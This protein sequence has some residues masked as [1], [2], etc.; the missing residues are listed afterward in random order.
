MTETSAVKFRFFQNT[1]WFLQNVVNTKNTK[2]SP[3]SKMPEMDW[4]SIYNL[5]V[6]GLDLHL[7]KLIN[8][9]LP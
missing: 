7:K 5:E 6:H 1:G 3:I 2:T 8:V 4:I 9:P